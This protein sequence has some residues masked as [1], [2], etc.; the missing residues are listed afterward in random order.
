VVVVL[1]VVGGAAA[2]PTWDTLDTEYTF[3]RYLT[4]FR[5]VSLRAYVQLPKLLARTHTLTHT[6]THGLRSPLSPSP[7]Q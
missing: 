6:H 5:K 4:D 2:R 3:T 7:P 1:A